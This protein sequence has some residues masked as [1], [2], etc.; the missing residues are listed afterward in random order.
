MSQD[1]AVFEKLKI[2]FILKGKILTMRA[3]LFP[4]PGL[5]P[6]KKLSLHYNLLFL[7]SQWS[8]SSHLILSFIAV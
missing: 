6:A 1:N 5:T 4:M 8:T 7:F 3:K 2:K